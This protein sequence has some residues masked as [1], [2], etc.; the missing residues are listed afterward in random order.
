PK[1]SL[2]YITA[3]FLGVLFPMFFLFL[4]DLLNRRVRGRIDLDYLNIPIG[5]EI[6]E[7]KVTETLMFKDNLRTHFCESI[8]LLRTNL[9]FLT[10]NL[11]QGNKVIF[12][13]SSISREGKSFIAINLAAA[14]AASGKKIL[15]IDTDLRQSKVESYLGMKPSKGLT[16][17]L[18]NKVGESE[19]IIIKSGDKFPFDILPAGPTPPNPAELLANGIFNAQLAKLKNQYDIILVDTAPVG[20]VADTLLIS[21]QADCTLY[22]VRAGHLLKSMT[23][24]IQDLKENNRLQNISIVVNGLK[25]SANGGYGYGY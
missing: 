25:P 19:E 1:K 5:A 13:T 16:H 21:D 24:L 20:L 10:G 2:V 18:A 8:R 9:D 11:N 23:P 6:P 12:V 15:L 7:I 4:L 14:F 22:V 3:G 17:V